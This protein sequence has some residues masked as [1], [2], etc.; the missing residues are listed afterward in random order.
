[1]F[2]DGSCDT[3]KTGVTLLKIQL[4]ITGIIYFLFFYIFTIVIIFLNY[5]VLLYF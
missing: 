4:A 2:S 5:T 1:M 3:L